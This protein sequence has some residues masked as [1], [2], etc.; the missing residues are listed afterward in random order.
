MPEE[1]RPYKGR[2]ICSVT[3]FKVKPLKKLT[4]HKNGISYNDVSTCEADA[5]SGFFNDLFGEDFSGKCQF[6]AN[7]TYEG[8]KENLIISLGKICYSCE[9]SLNGTKIKE[10]FTPPYEAVIDK[11]LLRDENELI[12]TVSNTAANAFV[13]FNLPEEWEQKHIGPYHEKALELEKKLLSGG[14]LGEV[15]IFEAGR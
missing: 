13:H 1:S 7:F 3:D 5:K 9:I 11:S 14:I 6:R 4:L 12:I 10:L 15:A 2:K 8:E